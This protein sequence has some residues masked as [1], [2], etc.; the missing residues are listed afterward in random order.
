MTKLKN[1]LIAGVAGLTV[2]ASVSSVFAADIV[3]IPEP[4]IPEVIVPPSPIGGWYLRGDIGYAGAKF[5]GANYTTID[6]NCGQCGGGSPTFGENSLD[7][8]LKGSF[9]LGG[10]VGYQVTD[11][12]RT[13][14]TVDYLT[15]AK[16]SGSTS[17]TCTANNAYVDCVSNDTAKMSALSILANAYIDLGNFNG[18]TPYVGAGIGGTRIKWGDLTNTIDPGFDQSGSTVHYGSASWRFTWALMAGLSYDLTQSLKLDAGYRFRRIQ[19]GEMF[20]ATKDIGRGFDKSFDIHDVRVGL[21]YQFGGYSSP[22]AYNDM[23]TPVYK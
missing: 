12:F 7:G 8:K 6:N 9:L 22:V 17:G 16:F 14:L 10:G 4:V 3:D 5:K 1:L 13:D 15:R 20:G 2:T 19:G 18:F 11:Y 21:R 23:T